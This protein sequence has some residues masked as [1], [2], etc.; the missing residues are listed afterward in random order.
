MYQDFPSPK[1]Y[2]KLKEEF[3][4]M[5]QTDFMLYLTQKKIQSR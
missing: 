4:S 3:I 2:T 5:K 1:K